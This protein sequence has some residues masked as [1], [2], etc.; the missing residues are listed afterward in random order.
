MAPNAKGIW[1]PRLT[2]GKFVAHPYKPKIHYPYKPPKPPRHHMSIKEAMT[3]EGAEEL[4]A[5]A[6]RWL[7]EAARIEKSTPE[8]TFEQRVGDMLDQKRINVKAL[9]KL[10]DDVLADGTIQKAEFRLKI[11]GTLM[12]EA[13]SAECDAL[14]DQYDEDKGGQIDAEE[15]RLAFVRI[16]GE[17]RQWRAEVLAPRERAAQLRVR[18]LSAQE[19]A[20]AVAQAEA[21]E[22]ELEGLRSELAGTLDVQLGLVMAKKK[23]NV[24]D[25]VGAWAVSRRN[26][27][28]RHEFRENVRLL[29][30]VRA[31]NSPG[32]QRGDQYTNAE[33]DVLFDKID[34]DKSG[35]LDVKEA[36]AALRDLQEKASQAM[37][38]QEAKASQA[39]RTRRRASQKTQAA[40]RPD[41]AGDPGSPDGS[42]LD[43]VGSMPLPGG[44]SE[45]YGTDDADE[46]SPL[47]AG[48]SRLA[49]LFSPFL[50]SS[51]DD[52]KE[53]AEARKRAVEQ[54]AKQALHR[55]QARGLATGWQTWHAW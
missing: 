37:A 50:S 45:L 33:L 6:K 35:Y 53:Q 47:S 8:P 31:G 34:D 26:E 25:M 15:M 49:G 39:A 42:R 48:R 28:T 29:L 10:W 13:T 44:A 11:R 55:I 40:L 46:A 20:A 23:I 41:Q 19:A 2:M 5:I 12:P 36:R 18:A 30:P 9:L 43:G 24:G 54:R 17:A 32:G 27:L 22:A 51:S 7:E 38:R 21:L 4:A 3:H 52:K 1:T 14:F 16:K